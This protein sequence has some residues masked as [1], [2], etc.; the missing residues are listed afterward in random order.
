MGVHLVLDKLLYKLNKENT[1]KALNRLNSI[2]AEVLYNILIKN[3]W[4]YGIQNKLLLKDK[5]GFEVELIGRLEKVFI[6]FQKSNKVVVYE[7]EDFYRKCEI[8]NMDRA[9]YIST[10]TFANDIYEVNHTRPLSSS[11][12]L[13]NGVKFLKTQVSSKIFHSNEFNIYNIHFFKYLPY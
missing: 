5:F 9:Y 11:I 8:I 7:Y 2:D 13:I 4:K 3:C 12:Q 10:G 6:K 1:K